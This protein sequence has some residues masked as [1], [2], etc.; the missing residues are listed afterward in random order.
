MDRTKADIIFYGGTIVTMDEN[1]PGDG[2]FSNLPKVEAVAIAGDRILSVGSLGD[3][4]RL[5][6]SKTQTIFLNGQTLMP[7]F[8]ETHQHACLCAMKRSVYTDISAMKYRSYADVSAAMTQRISELKPGNWGLFFG[9][10]PELIRDLPLLSASYLDTNFS[11]SFP[12]VVIGQSGHVCWV[13]QLA[14][15]AAGIK[16]STP[17]PEGGTIV[18][19]EN[20]KPT[21]QLFEE[22]AMMLVMSHSPQPDSA[23]VAQGF[24]DQWRYYASVG[25]TTATD[26]AYM[27]SDSTNQM[28]RY[29]ADQKNCPIRVGLYQVQHAK[30]EDE[31]K[32]GKPSKEITIKNPCC[33]QQLFSTTS[34]TDKKQKSSTAVKGVGNYSELLW[35]AGIKLTGDGS[36]HCGT[37]AVREPF[38]QTPL[39]EILGFPKAPSYG[40]LNMDSQALIDTVKWFHQKGTQIA[41]HTHGERASEQALR[42]YE[43]VLNEVGIQDNRHRLEHCGLT[44]VEQIKRAAEVNVG[45]SFFVDHLRY[46]G[47]VYQTD[48]FGD[49]VN[50]WTPLSEATKTGMKWTIH[51]DHPTFPGDAVP[52]A[53]LTSAVTRCTRDDP[54]TPYGPEYRVS[55]H[56]ALKAYTVNAAWMLHRE[57]DLGT[58]T[59]GKKA[60]LVV[61]SK[62]PYEVDPFKLEDEIDVVETFLNGRTNGFAHVT[63]IPGSRINILEPN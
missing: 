20:G 63:T 2:S 55:I 3:V 49:R 6:G 15:D 29:L 40:I 60:D 27:S 19:D 9:W 47:L 34:S 39:T 57:N 16:P 59:P 62:N 45:I 25:I 43:Q 42:A 1:M 50:R 61:L 21:G 18:K 36:P 14:L 12:V 10:D 44:T 51:Q 17:S 56:E 23:T 58:I 7:G 33:P 4:F 48:I 13:N 52:L 5:A 35:E 32:K 53:N 38:M 8:I 26:L 22:P 46:Y 24:I 41:I 31:W 54:T 11:S 37:A 28:L 30:T